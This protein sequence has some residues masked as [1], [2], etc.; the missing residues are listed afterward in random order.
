MVDPKQIIAEVDSALAERRAARMLT[1]HTLLLRLDTETRGTAANSVA[2]MALQELRELARG[3][4]R[5]LQAVATAAAKR[6]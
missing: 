6:R 3:W 1:L 2:R 5:E 4:D